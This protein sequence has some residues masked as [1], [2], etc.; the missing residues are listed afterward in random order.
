MS[1]QDK[2]IYQYQLIARIRFIPFY[3]AFFLIF[4]LAISF[5]TLAWQEPWTHVASA[6]LAALLFYFFLVRFIYLLADVPVLYSPRFIIWSFTIPTSMLTLRQTAKLE[7]SIFLLGT[8]LMLW[9]ALL[10]QAPILRIALLFYLGL[11]LPRFILFIYTHL[12]SHSKR[13]KFP[14]THWIRLSPTTISI[15]IR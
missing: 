13:K 11:T 4:L 6:Y 8:S 3:L 5:F 7:W 1:L 12:L 15:Y 9:M 2:T 14:K 10:I